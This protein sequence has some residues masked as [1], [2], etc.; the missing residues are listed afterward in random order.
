MT[1]ATDPQPEVQQVE[2]LPC[3]FC[4]GYGLSSAYPR[5]LRE[6]VCGIIECHTDGCYAMIV[7]DTLPKA[8]AAWNRRADTEG[9]AAAHEAGRVEGVREAAEVAERHRARE[10]VPPCAY[11]EAANDIAAS[12]RAL[13]KEPTK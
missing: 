12:I 1:P 10:G 13:S 6:Q 8:I 5:I 3:P 2:L 11:D 7:A 4:G 9:R